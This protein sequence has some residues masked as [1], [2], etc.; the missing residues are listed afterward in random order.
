VDLLVE[1]VE[2]PRWVAPVA[3][4]E[5]G[6]DDIA[7][8]QVQAGYAAAWYPSSEPRPE[9][10]TTYQDAERAAHEAGTGAWA[11]CTTLGR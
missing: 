10:Y 4:V 8:G 7:L 2:T 11:N 9:R 6:G 1:L 5:L 3:Y